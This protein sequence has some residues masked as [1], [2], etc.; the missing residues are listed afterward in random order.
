MR[1]PSTNPLLIAANSLSILGLLVSLLTMFFSLG[2]FGYW[3]GAIFS[4][5]GLSCHAMLVWER[6]NRKSL[7]KLTDLQLKT[8]E[9]LKIALK[10]KKYTLIASNESSVLIHLSK[11]LTVFYDIED[12]PMFYSDHSVQAVPLPKIVS[13]EAIELIHHHFRIDPE[14]SSLFPFEE[15]PTKEAEVIKPLLDMIKRERIEKSL[16]AIR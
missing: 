16:K 14:V 9:Q 4:F 12:G 7:F 1:T 3:I 11:D 8:I 6:K 5:I 10:N 2:H 13:V 15:D